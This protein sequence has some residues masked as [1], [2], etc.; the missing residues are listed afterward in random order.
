MLER[1]KKS[2]SHKLKRLYKVGFTA[3]IESTKEEDLGEDASKQGRINDIDA[4]ANITLVSPFVDE[5][6]VEMFDKE[7]DVSLNAIKDGVNENEEVVE[8]VTVSAAAQSTTAGTTVEEVT[9]AQT[10]QKMKSTTPKSKRVVIPEREQGISKRTQTLA[11]PQDKGKA[12]MIEPVKHKMKDQAKID[13]DHLLAER[14]QAEEQEELSIDERAKLFQ[15]LLE[16][17]RKHFAKKES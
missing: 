5:D 16:T 11:Q 15:Q 12:K 1:S 10:L 3:R 8:E 2:R 13:A 7:E 14:L 9:L 17:R 6:D 4:D